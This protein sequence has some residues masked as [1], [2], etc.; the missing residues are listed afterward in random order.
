MGMADFLL[1]FHKSIHTLILAFSERLQSYHLLWI[2]LPVPIVQVL[3]SPKC[4][5]KEKKEPISK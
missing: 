4:K 5:N 2:W 1:Q 3:N